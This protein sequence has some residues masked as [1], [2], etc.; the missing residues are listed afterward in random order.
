MGNRYLVGQVKKSGNTVI[1]TVE[2]ILDS[3][4]GDFYKIMVIKNNQ[5]IEDYDA[6][7]WLEIAEKWRDLQRQYFGEVFKYHVNL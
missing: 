3:V 2:K 7:N 5:Y 1:I 6:E 4:L